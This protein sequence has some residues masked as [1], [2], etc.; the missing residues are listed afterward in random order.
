[1]LLR[2]KALRTLQCFKFFT[3]KWP[4][5]LV[6]L[7]AYQLSLLPL[8]TSFLLT[9]AQSLK[10]AWGKKIV[11]YLCPFVIPDNFEHLRA[12]GGYIDTCFLLIPKHLWILNSNQLRV[13]LQAIILCS[14]V[15]TGYFFYFIRNA[16]LKS[17]SISHLLSIKY[18]IYLVGWI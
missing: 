5:L 1:M 7:S 15:N 11:S 18:V 13:L 8:N 4:N 6:D 2:M 17:V 9:C 16:W 14:P 3:G 10:S 12:L